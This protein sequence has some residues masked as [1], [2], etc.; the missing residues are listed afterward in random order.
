MKSLNGLKIVITAGPT[1]ER[2]DPVRYITNDSSGKMG[3]ALAEAA[4][5][6][7]ANVF[8]ISGPV[9]LP[10]P[11]GVSRVD[12][13]S[14]DDMLAAC[15]DHMPCDIFISAAAVADFKVLTPGN[16]K[17]KKK[18]AADDSMVLHLVKNPDIIKIISESGQ[19]HFTVGFAAETHDVKENAISKITRKKINLILANDVSDKSIGFN[20]DE[21]ELLA[22]DE[23]FNEYPFPRAAKSQL[24]SGIF[25]L[26]MKLQ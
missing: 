22:I 16:I 6:A 9:S 26:I 1:V 17:I 3:Y 10:T 14:A 20:N 5:K 8:L 11:D 21:N 25:E 19:C 23:H 4:H 7:G 24:A 13:L 15:Q 18:Y 12:V 2:I